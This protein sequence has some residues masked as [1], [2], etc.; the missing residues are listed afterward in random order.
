MGQS[1][2]SKQVNIWEYT[3]KSVI[4][5]MLY[6]IW[7]SISKEDITKTWSQSRAP[8]NYLSGLGMEEIEG[9]PWKNVVFIIYYISTEVPDPDT[10]IGAQCLPV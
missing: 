3:Q 5:K 6:I 10:R 7:S 4:N 1:V 8:K 2:Q 9:L